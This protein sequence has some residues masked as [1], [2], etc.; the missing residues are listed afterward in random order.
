MKKNI[1][2]SVYDLE[3]GGI[4][5]SLINMLESFDYEHHNVD[6]LVFSHKGDLMGLIPV[7]VNLLPERKKYTVFRKSL[8]QCL[9]ERNLMAVAVR[10]LSKVIA[11]ASSVRKKLKEG[12]GY[13]QMQWESRLSSYYIRGPEK[14]YDLVI[15]NGWPHDV[16]LKRVKAKKKLAWIHTDYSMLEINNKMDLK[17]WS[18]FDY[19]ASISEA[20]TESFLSRYPVLKDKIVQIE[21]ITSPE[22]IKKMSRAEDTPEFSKTFNI[23]SVGRLSYVK[24]YDMAVQALK[25]LHGRGMTDIR[26]YVIGYGG[27]EQELRDL[28]ARHQLEE[29]FILLGKKSNPYPYIKMC[30]VY[31]QPSRYEGKAVTITEAQILGKPVIITNYPTAQ[32][33]VADGVDGRICDLSPEGIADAIHLMYQSLDIRNALI[34]NLEDKDYSNSYELHKLYQLIPSTNNKRKKEPLYT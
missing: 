32:S 8:R 7:Q 18:G 11:K 19:I 31:V 1:L 3:I 22:F 17:V 15:S 34:S 10:L 12:P 13:I 29:S 6:L 20:C 16:V 2:I 24:G 4:E 25:A 28:I 33:Q 26:W 27:Y 14:E 5:R 30:D 23:V 21:N 9:S